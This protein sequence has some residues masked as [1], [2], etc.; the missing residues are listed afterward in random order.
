MPFRI[1]HLVLPGG[2][3][4]ELRRSSRVLKRIPILVKGP[5]AA[6][7]N[8]VTAVVNREGAL[9]LAPS[10]YP[11]GTELDIQILTN[12]KATKA[13]VIWHGGEERPGVFKLGIELLEDLPEFWG[14][15][16]AVVQPTP[17]PTQ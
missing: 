7:E 5:M 13:R 10:F 17:P 6:P 15:E 16:Y 12:G 8:A 9:I 4:S 1:M 14:V 2:W 11:E 3:M